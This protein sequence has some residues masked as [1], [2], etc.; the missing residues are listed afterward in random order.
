V[1]FV[2]QK[3]LFLMIVN[4]SMNLLIK[5]N[6]LDFE[7]GFHNMTK[8]IWN[9]VSLVGDQSDYVNVLGLQIT[10]HMKRKMKYITQ[11]KYVR[12]YCYKL[13]Q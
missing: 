6:E 7:H 5:G 10:T 12:S 9:E 2:D 8:I 13:V 4:E 11:K 1:E 3:E